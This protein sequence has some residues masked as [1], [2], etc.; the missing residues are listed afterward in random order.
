MS[1]VGILR[2]PIV[3]AAVF[4]HQ[5]CAQSAD[6][7]FSVL[8]SRAKVS[9]ALVARNAAG[10]SLFQR[11]F[12]GG[13]SN[14]LLVQGRMRSV[15]S[16]P[17]GTLTRCTG[18]GDNGGVVGFYSAIGSVPPYS[19]FAYFNGVYADVVP[20]GADP[21]WG[22]TVNAVSPNGLMAG[23][24]QAADGS[25][26]IF[27]TYGATYNTIQVGGVEILD[28]TGVNDSGLLVAQELFATMHGDIVSSV[29]I[30]SGVVSNI[31]FPGSVVTYAYNINDNGDV[32]GYYYNLD[33]VSHGFIFSSSKNAYFGPIDVPNA[34]GGT[35]LTGI[36]SDDVVTG[37]AIF[38]GAAVN[39]AIIGF[40]A[41]LRIKD[42]R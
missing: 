14:C 5:A 12:P 35:T 28:A 27:L 16:D 41:G 34:T 8:R 39:T 10:A 11:D 20:P 31:S 9:E 32:V 22:S 25:Y 3:F 21:I 40:P 4:C 37:S 7:S 26:R 19:G 42:G 13:V 29:L 6:Y 1:P 2:M 23:T 30:E 33:Y 17:K 38:P 15:V 36:T 24:Y 18:L